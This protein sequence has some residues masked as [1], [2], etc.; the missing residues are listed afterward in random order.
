MILMLDLKS[1]I[2]VR[3]RMAAMPFFLAFIFACFANFVMAQDVPQA[4][5]DQ[6]QASASANELP[7]CL[8]EGAVGFVLL[9]RA[10]QTD[11]FGPST[12][13]VVEICLE[14]NEAFSSAW[15]CVEQAAIDALETARLIGRDAI[16]D[17]CVRALADADV[18]ERLDQDASE[19]RSHF[20]PSKRLFG[21]TMYR[22]FRGCPSNVAEEPAVEGSM[23]EGTGFSEAECT[24]FSAFDQFISE[25]SANELRAMM[26]VLESLPEEERIG[27]LE[28]FG[29]SGDAIKVISESMEQSDERALGLGMLGAGLLGRHHPDLLQEA[30]AFTQS[31]DD[32][33]NEV[34]AGFLE[35]MSS[36]ALQGYENDCTG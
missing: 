10:T 34:A 22:A 2:D 1:E 3:K 21:G 20:M 36:A 17:V 35:M 6:C 25:T 7:D 29:L 24:A 30:F 9:E 33:A 18:V 14:Q 5:I 32:M 31:E 16:A 26:P 13:P 15:T 23:D 11:Y 28:E 27:A 4:V 8:G 19:L 12:E